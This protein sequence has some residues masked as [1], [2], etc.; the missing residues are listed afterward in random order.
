MIWEPSEEQEAQAQEIALS[1]MYSQHF[2]P[3]TKE[4]FEAELET[5]TQ[6]VIFVLRC[7]ADNARDRLQELEV[8]NFT[9]EL[10]RLHAKAIREEMLAGI[11][12][13]QINFED[14][15][16]RAALEQQ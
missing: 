12:L 1:W 3:T 10:A 6:F 8:S 2:S 7:L 13:D 14:L 11:E 5:C 15:E 4:K 16:I 9:A